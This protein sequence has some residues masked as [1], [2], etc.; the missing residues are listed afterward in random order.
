MR[1]DSGDRFP[2]T[3]ASISHCENGRAQDEDQECCSR[4]GDY[5]DDGDDGGNVDDDVDYVDD[6]ECDDEHKPR[7]AKVTWAR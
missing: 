2:S 4:Q 7:L 3:D 1:I 5:Y 6:D